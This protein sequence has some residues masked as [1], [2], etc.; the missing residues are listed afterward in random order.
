V[1]KEA[2]I[3]QIPVG[4]ECNM[5]RQWNCGVVPGDGRLDSA[6]LM[7]RLQVE[8][9]EG[10]PGYRVD[11]TEWMEHDCAGNWNADHFKIFTQEYFTC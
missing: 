8:V 1:W 2:G 3:N 5:G 4:L 7:T 6:I 9:I 10:R 11:S